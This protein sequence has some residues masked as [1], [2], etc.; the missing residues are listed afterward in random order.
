V[1]RERG[2]GLDPAAANGDEWWRD[3]AER[4]LAWWAESGTE[5]D[6]FD[7]TELGV[8]DP[9]HSARWG[10]LFNAAANVGL[11]EP[12]GYRQSRRPTRHGGVCR[13]WRGIKHESGT[14][15]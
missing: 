3:S 7:L 10:A 14:A 11:I 13:V 2:S 8:P 1:P 6:A 4:A 12:V 15:A 9:D 5:F